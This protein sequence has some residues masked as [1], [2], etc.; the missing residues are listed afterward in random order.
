MSKTPE[1]SPPSQ[2]IDLINQGQPL[3]LDP[4]QLLLEAPMLLL[5]WPLFLAV[6]LPLLPLPPTPCLLIQPPFCRLLLA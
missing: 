1:Q 4:Q 5:L 2:L 6:L 3:S